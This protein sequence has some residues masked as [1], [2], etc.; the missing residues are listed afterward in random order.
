[1]KIGFFTDTYLPVVHGVEISIET[2][3]KS[4]EKMGHQVFIYAPYHPGYKDKNPGV[5]RL[6][7]VRIIKKPEMRFAFPLAAAGHLKK[8]IDFKLDVVHAHTPFS[9]GIL[10]K[11]IS[12]RQNIPLIYTH[13]TDY[14]EYAKAYMKEK[15]ILP[16][17]AR[18]WSGWFSNASDA[19]L[20]P[21]LKIKK[22]LKDYGVKKPI[23][24]LP[25]GVDLEIFKKTRKSLSRAKTLKNKLSVSP[26]DQALIFVGRMG[27]EKNIDFLIRAFGEIKKKRNAVKFILIGDGPYLGELK[28]LAAKLK[29]SESIIF[30][31]AI[32][33]ETL[34][35]YY[36]L[37]DVF[38]FSSLT[39]TQ[40]IV[41]IEAIGSSL[42][43]VALKDAAFS[44]A[45]IDNQ[46]GFL[47]SPRSS[48][49]LFADKILKILRDPN[50]QKRFSGNSFKIAQK[51]SDRS[52]A[53]KLLRIY[54]SLLS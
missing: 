34:P 42:P 5:F 44:G 53:K 46:N 24:I 3:R 11:F 15:F 36:Q 38:V 51:F 6:K 14:P 45:V 48:A 49:K 21:S 2:F 35:F 50:I 37:A 28:V 41:I 30:T 25:T 20:A 31:G 27:K 1:M 12:A 4:L 43:I 9:L 54:K 13:H 22:Q 17:L 16:S 18:W 52:Q 47:I 26:K 7:S 40:G 32:S 33:H 10:G 8:I 29:I 23:Y 39:E 19:I